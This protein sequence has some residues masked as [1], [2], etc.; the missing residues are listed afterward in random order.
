MLLVA[1]R[2]ERL[3]PLTDTRPKCLL[4]VGGEPLI[5]RA[6]DL[7]GERGITRF[8]IVDGWLGEQV[9]DTLTA[10]F[11]ADWFR[12]VRNAA[13]AGTNN[14]YSLWLARYEK[15]EPLLL[16]D[17]DL[18]FAPEVLDLLLDDS[19][20]NRLLL[21][22][23][24]GLGDEEM[25]VR[26]RADETV[27]DLGKALPPDEAAGESVGIELFSPE[28]ALKLFAALERRVQA[29]PGREEFYEAAF[30]ELIRAGE[31]VHALDI[32]D[33]ACLEIDTAEDLARARQLFGPE[34]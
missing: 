15:P 23:E 10:R 33:L 11:P 13:W 34:P 31:R 19:R 30:V 22:S 4:E 16:L 14:A 2:G 21:R 18:A 12:F 25:K 1:G 3:R 6:V 20:P 27:D 9:R 5:A 28:F 32:G 24:G 17:G 7:L 8:T 26:L 29:G